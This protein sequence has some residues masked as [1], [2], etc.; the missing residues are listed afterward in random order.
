MENDLRNALREQQFELHYQ[1]QVN[2]RTGE[3]AGAEALIRWNHPERGMV[4]PVEFIPHAERT[5]LIIKL[6]QWVLE[7]ACQHLAAWARSPANSGLVIA[8]NVSAQQFQ[9]PDFYNH[10]TAAL[11]R[12][13][14]DPRQLKLEL[15]ESV[16]AGD[17]DSLIELMRRI[18]ALGI[19]FSLDDFGTGYSSLSYLSRL[20]LDQLKIDRSFVGSIESGDNNVVIC[21]ATIGL[22]HSLKLKVVAEGVENDAQRHFLST[23]H[24]CDLLQGYLYSRPLAPAAFE[25]WLDQFRTAKPG[26]ASSR[27]GE[28]IALYPSKS[29]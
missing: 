17:V 21:S 1:P 14:A 20:P 26:R 3:V 29:A 12:S 10:V 7:T 19:G 24:G 18:K 13:G 11:E 16:F 27:K 9:S 2:D 22:A 4:S 23:V 6:G 15:T 8:V 5:G 28:L 25:R